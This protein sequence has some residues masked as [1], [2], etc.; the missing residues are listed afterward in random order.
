MSLLADALANDIRS[1]DGKHD[2]GAGELAEKLIERGWQRTPPAEAAA[3]RAEVERLA[4]DNAELRERCDTL[5]EKLLQAN[6]AAK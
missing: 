3:L 2:M 5:L 4:K 1:I 6:D